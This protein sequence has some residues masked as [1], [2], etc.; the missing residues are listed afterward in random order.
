MSA[1]T[2]VTDDAHSVRFVFRFKPL[3]E[4]REVRWKGAKHGMAWK[5][6]VVED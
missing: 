4:A 3:P 1:R 5:S 2:V 6:G